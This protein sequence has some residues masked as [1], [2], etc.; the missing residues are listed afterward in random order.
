MAATGRDCGKDAR[1]HARQGSLP[2]QAFTG[3]SCRQNIIGALKPE[4]GPKVGY[5]G[6]GGSEEGTCC[7]VARDRILRFVSNGFS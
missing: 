6:G 4:G 1:P 2:F 7:A 3:K 5:A